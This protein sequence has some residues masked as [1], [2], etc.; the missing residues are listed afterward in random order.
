MEG[1]AMANA[2]SAR[3]IAEE[4]R[5]QLRRQQQF[6]LAA[7]AVTAALADIPE[8]E[9]VVLFG[10]LARP[11]HREVPRFQPYHRHRIPL[12]HEVKDVDLAVWVARLDRLDGLRRAL[13]QAVGQLYREH[14][15]G[16]ANHQVELF[17]FEPGTDRYLGR[18]CHFR[19]C[20]KGHRDC[21]AENCGRE[22]FLK[23]MDGFQLWP[24][25]L[26]PERTVRLFDRATGTMRRAAEMAVQPS[27]TAA[28][29]TDPPAVERGTGGPR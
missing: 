26:A 22:P 11:L 1:F 20:P 14:G 27:T 13:N 15:L 23:Q 24:D 18:V 6:R 4:D 12:L 9:A 7:D 3:S 16:V 19:T 25:A 10:S 29:G 17:L 5:S 28:R 2:P 8:V 21:R